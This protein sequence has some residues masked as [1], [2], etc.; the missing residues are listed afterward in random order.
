MSARVS[1]RPRP[2][3]A[4]LSQRRLLRPSGKAASIAEG[5]GFP[6]RRQRI[7]KIPWIRATHPPALRLIDF[8]SFS[9]LT[10]LVLTGFALLGPTKKAPHLSSR[11]FFPPRPASD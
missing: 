8:F 4:P 5:L 2:P 9:T 11:H 1:P 6:D 3:S 7:Q 10:L